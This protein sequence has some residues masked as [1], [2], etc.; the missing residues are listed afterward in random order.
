MEK[1]KKMVKE[2]PLVFFLL[3]T[4]LFFGIFIR[5]DF[6]T[7]SY[8]VFMQSAKENISHFL[9]SGRF[10]TAFAEAV[11]RGLNL[12][13]QITYVCSFLLAILANTYAMNKLF[14]IAKEEIED[15]KMAIL[16][17]VLIIINLFSFE[18]YLFIEKGIL[19]LSVLFNVLAVEKL[20]SYWKGNK[21][22]IFWVL[23]Y[24]I[25]ANFAY[26][27]TVGIFV[28]ISLIFILQYAKNFKEF[29]KNNILTAFLYGIPAI[30]N[31]AI[32]K[33]L[34]HNN[35]LVG[36]SNIALAIEKVVNGTKTMLQNTYNVLPNYVFLI[37][38][39]IVLAI[40]LWVILQKIR[41]EKK[42][43][44][45]LLEPLYLIIGTLAVTIVPQLMQNA[46][47]IWFVARSTYTF[48]AIIGIL[49]LY[50]VLRHKTSK[51]INRVLMAIGII[52]LVVQ[53]ISFQKI[54]VDHYITNYLDQYICE[55]IEKEV[56]N[57]EQTTGKQV[58]KVAFYEDSIMEYAYP[59]LYCNGDTNVK[60]LLPSWNRKHVINYYLH[61]NLEEVEAEEKIKE[62]FKQENW[63][64]FAKEQVKI[65]ANTLHLCIY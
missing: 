61:R 8:T 17:S 38:L 3:I 53:L 57:Y 4:I 42:G 5:M 24:L 29:I 6:A 45:Q 44:Y 36:E 33:F 59:N 54:G 46:N 28:A 11:V 9:M 1:L 2:K 10:I 22:S 7:D 13:N 15:K 63:T 30:L 23:G 37:F 50:C 18:L 25:L 47:S 14:K 12:S 19:W 32:A 40:T 34:F 52:Y 35:R 49:I 58:T 55:K 43:Y 16:A 64:Q 26:Q 20:I 31:Y 48:P 51:K 65:Q 60:A 21:K 27:G 62:E 56:Q 39:G 41:K